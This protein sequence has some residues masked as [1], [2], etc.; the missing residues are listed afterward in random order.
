MVAQNVLLITGYGLAVVLCTA[1]GLLV[2]QAMS[3]PRLRVSYNEDS[4]N[5]RATRRDL[6][7]YAITVIPRS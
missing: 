5:W 3:R 7:L 6:L 2:A 4:N 1:L